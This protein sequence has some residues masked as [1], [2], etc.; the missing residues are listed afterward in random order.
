MPVPTLPEVPAQRGRVDANSLGGLVT[1]QVPE[2]HGNMP[3]IASPPPPALEHTS[4]ANM[5]AATAGPRSQKAEALTLAPPARVSQQQISPMTLPPAD[6]TQQSRIPVT[7]S[8]AEA[9]HQ[10]SLAP[11]TP[12]QG[13]AAVAKS[14]AAGWLSWLPWLSSEPPASSIQVDLAVLELQLEPH[15]RAY[16]LNWEDLAPLLEELDSV[17]ELKRATKYPEEFPK[18]LTAL[19]EPLARKAAAAKLRPRLEPHLTAYGLDWADAELALPHFKS[20][21][22][23]QSLAR[24]PSDFVQRLAELSEVVSQKIAALDCPSLGLSNEV[25]RTAGGLSTAQNMTFDPWKGHRESGA[26]ELGGAVA[27]PGYKY[28]NTAGPAFVVPSGAHRTAGGI[29]MTQI[30]TFDP[31][32]GHQCSGTAEPAGVGGAASRLR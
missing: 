21:Q 14:V 19:S 4:R 23:L 12:Q 24:R 3:T 6:L 20:I 13:P 11:K 16:G 8:P 27:T 31:W 22:E 1:E 9:V 32:K 10:K 25:H 29:S 15:L 26:N 18:R 28:G 5:S 7:L 2:G 17:G 30:A